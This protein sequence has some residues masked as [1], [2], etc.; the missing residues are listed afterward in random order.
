MKRIVAFLSIVVAA[1][2]AAQAG[3]VLSFAELEAVLTD[4]LIVE[5][6]EGLSLHGG[7]TYPAP[8]PL[9]DGNVGWGMEPG[10]TYAA[11]DTLRY[12]NPSDDIVL[13]ATGPAPNEMTLTFDEPQSAVGFSLGAGGQSATVVFYSDA[14]VLASIDTPA[15]FVGWHAFAGITSVSIG[16]DATITIDDLGWGAHEVGTIPLPAP[17][18]R[19]QSVPMLATKLTPEGDELFTTW[20]VASCPSADYNLIYGRLSDVAT[21]TLAGAECGTGSGGTIEWVP[22]ISDD[23]FFLLVGIDDAGEAESGWG[24]DSVGAERNGTTPSGQCGVTDKDLFG[25]C[26]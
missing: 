20:D 21:Y 25:V 1:G 15:A 14:T 23:L 24:V 3:Q 11:D 26:P 12:R 13:E 9:H 18:G 5:D 7:S 16:A 8:N 22:A 17:D 6:F 4:Q 19:D 10:V 2:A